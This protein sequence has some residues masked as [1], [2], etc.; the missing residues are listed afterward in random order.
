MK[1][2]RVS[3]LGEAVLIGLAC[4]AVYL[5]FCI[6]LKMK[7][8]RLFWQWT[9]EKLKRRGSPPAVPPGGEDAA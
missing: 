6:L 7:E 4:A 5:A 8:P 3:N 1:N 9:M 2:Q